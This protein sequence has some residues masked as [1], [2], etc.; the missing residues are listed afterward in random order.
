M[1]LQQ[2]QREKNSFVIVLSLG[3][4]C[5]A[6]LFSLAQISTGISSDELLWTDNPCVPEAPWCAGTSQKLQ[7]A[8]HKHTSTGQQAKFWRLHS[9]PCLRPCKKSCYSLLYLTRWSFRLQPGSSLLRVP[10]MSLNYQAQ[11]E[12]SSPCTVKVQ[13]GSPIQMGKQ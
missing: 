5:P 8:A 2:Y 6:P 12:H 7:Q 11:V 4:L 3:F 10:W 9:K 13:S 1:K